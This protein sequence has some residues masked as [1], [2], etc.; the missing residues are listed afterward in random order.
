MPE[1][2]NLAH[3]ERAENKI[4]LFIPVYN[5][6]NMINRNI[7]MAFYTLTKSRYTFEIFIVDDNSTD[8]SSRY[9][10]VINRVSHNSSQSI[11]YLF[12]HQGPSR[13]ENLARSFYQATGDIICFIDADLSCDISFL[14]KAI[15]LLRSSDVDIVIGSRYIEGAR[16]RRRLMRKALS[17]V[18]NSVIRMLFKSKIKDHQCGLKVFK[19]STI[20]PIIDTMGYDEKFSRGW[21]WDAELLIRAQKAGCKIIEMPVDWH[22]ADKSTFDFTRELKCLKTMVKLKKELGVA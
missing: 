4:S 12:Y 14:V 7:K 6:K 1:E 19:K 2:M 5:M 18:Y 21:F 16:A 10:R 20:M 17:F 9:A 22:Y 15:H 11:R 13:R 8:K 3:K